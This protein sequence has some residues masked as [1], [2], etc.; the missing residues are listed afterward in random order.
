MDTERN[1]VEF[2]FRPLN[3]SQN[4]SG[5]Q[6]DNHIVVRESD[7]IAAWWI[8]EDEPPFGIKA[9]RVRYKKNGKWSAATIRADLT[10]YR[11]V[12]V[13]GTTWWLNDFTSWDEVGNYLGISAAQARRLMED[14]L[15]YSEAAIERLDMLSAL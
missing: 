11:L 12:T 4:G 9:G 7:K 10:G 14:R 3:S 5:Q 15:P 6:Y 1:I 2:A 8:K 13:L